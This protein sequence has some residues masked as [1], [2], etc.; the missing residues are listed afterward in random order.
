METLHSL[1]EGTTTHQKRNHMSDFSSPVQTRADELDQT[2]P[3]NARLL[4]PV[5]SRLP[6]LLA[7]ATHESFEVGMNSRFSD[8]LQQLSLIAMP[9]LLE[10]LHAQFSKHSISPQILSEILWWASRQS[11]DEW[12][13]EILQIMWSGFSHESSLVRDTTALALADFDEATARAHLPL[14]IEREQELPLKAD[15]RSLLRSL[16][17]DDQPKAR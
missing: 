14:A 17:P 6:E 7:N 5:D 4:S 1:S 2:G 10:A 12:R 9:D 15:M 16:M 11:R 3:G 8:G 13:R